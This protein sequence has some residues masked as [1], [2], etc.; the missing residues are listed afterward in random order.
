MEARV[1]VICIAVICDFAR[2]TINKRLLLRVDARGHGW[3]QLKNS[4]PLILRY[5]TSSDVTRNYRHGVQNLQ[6]LR[7]RRLAALSGSVLSQ[8]R[9]RCQFLPRGLHSMKSHDYFKLNSRYF[10]NL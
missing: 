3:Q 7:K 1:F 6:K 2:D 9:S 10:V 8:K 5:N 4:N